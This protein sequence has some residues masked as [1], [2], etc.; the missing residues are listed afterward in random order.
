MNNKT[1]IKLFKGYELDINNT[2]D[3]EL[4]IKV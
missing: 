3:T 1:L 4:I 2:G